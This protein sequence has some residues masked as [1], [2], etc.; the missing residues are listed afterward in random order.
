M[1][2][3]Y[4]FSIQKSANSATNSPPLQKRVSSANPALKPTEEFGPYAHHYAIIAGSHLKETSAA[5]SSV[6]IA[7]ISN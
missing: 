4:P 3:L 6:E 1:I 7:T 2:C 5:R